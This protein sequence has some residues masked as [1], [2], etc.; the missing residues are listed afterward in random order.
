[1]AWPTPS[2]EAEGGVLRSREASG[3]SVLSALSSSLKVPVGVPW[4][5]PKVPDGC[6]ATSL[7]GLKITFFLFFAWAMPNTPQETWNHLQRQ[8]SISLHPLQP[9]QTRALKTPLT[10]R[11]V[12]LKLP[13]DQ[14]PAPLTHI[15]LDYVSLAVFISA[16]LLLK[17][18]PF[19]LC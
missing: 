18:D 11:W 2:L 8:F 6:A 4:L 14:C 1:M 19:W 15:S 10:P 5:A 7:P 3:A 16:L 9:W 17:T 12:T 13:Y